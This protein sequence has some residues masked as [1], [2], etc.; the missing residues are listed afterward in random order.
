VPILRYD[1]APVDTSDAGVAARRLVN[2]AMGSKNITMG[3]STFAPG[4]GIFLHTH[5]CEE[6][7]IILD[8]AG[9]A[10]VDGETIALGQYDVS[11]IPPLVPHRFWNGSDRPMTICYFYPMTAGL[12]RDPVRDED[13]AANTAHS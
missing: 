8:G 11:F 2:A 1:Q 12:T 7:V 4:A 9:M 13:K 10:E 3:I 5:P 6:T